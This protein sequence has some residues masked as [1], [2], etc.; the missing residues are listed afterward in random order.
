[1]V[2]HT[3]FPPFKN[4]VDHTTLYLGPW[5]E[6][7]KIAKPA[8]PA[9]KFLAKSQKGGTTFKVSSSCILAPSVEER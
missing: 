5:L 3:P 1:M 9:A 6:F 8:G 7:R 4:R 2:L